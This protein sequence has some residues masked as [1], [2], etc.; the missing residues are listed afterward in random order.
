M[1]VL[2][3]INELKFLNEIKVLESFV[4][5][6]NNFT[7]LEKAKRVN[8]IVTLYFFQVSQENISLIDSIK[9]IEEGGLSLASAGDIKDLLENIGKFKYKCPSCSHNL[10]KASMPRRKFCPYCK[11]LL[12]CSIK[13]IDVRKNGYQEVIIGPMDIDERIELLSN[14]KGRT[15]KSLKYFTNQGKV[16]LAMRHPKRPCYEIGYKK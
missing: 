2:N 10:S 8:R 3:F 14:F 5:F 6:S 11:S 7:N 1:S 13:E 12:S 16:I 9:K 4:F 15:T